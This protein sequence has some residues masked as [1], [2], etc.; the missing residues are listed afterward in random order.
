[1]KNKLKDHFDRL[2]DPS[3]QKQNILKKTKGQLIIVILKNV[4]ATHQLVQTLNPHEICQ[5]I[6]LYSIKFIC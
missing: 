2:S 3:T 5:D 1:M 4:G 6:F